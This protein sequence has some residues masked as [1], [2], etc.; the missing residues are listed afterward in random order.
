MDKAKIE[1]LLDHLTL[2]LKADPEMRLD[3]KS[4]LR[5]HLDS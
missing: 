5:S 4:E 1:K 3:V 2:G